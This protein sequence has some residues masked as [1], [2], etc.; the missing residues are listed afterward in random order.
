MQRLIISPL[1]CDRLSRRLRALPRGFSIMEV[2]VVVLI[3]GVLISMCAPTYQLALEQSRADIAAA[4][5]RAI[6]AA[7]RLYWLSN[8]S[9]SGDLNQLETLGLVDSAVT[10]STVY[11]YAITAAESNTF[12]ASATRADSNV[13]SG[14]FTVDQTGTISGTISG[15]SQQSIQPGF[16]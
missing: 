3:M 6:W 15:V 13:W 1:A 2:M 12:S 14:T 16:Q 8:Q 7:E 10:T 4:N 11:V 5:L 9:Y